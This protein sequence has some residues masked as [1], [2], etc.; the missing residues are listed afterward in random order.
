MKL[1]VD[2]ERAEEREIVGSQAA[3]ALMQSHVGHLLARS[4]QAGIQLGF[5]N[6]LA[7]APA[8]A[9]EV[10]ASCKTNLRAT[11]ALLDVLATTDYATCIRDRY[12]LT[13]LGRTWL[14]AGKADYVRI[15]LLEWEWHAQLE[16]FLRS[17]R[18][19]DIHRNMTAENWRI[20][21]EAMS[22]AAHLW[23]PFFVDF[24]PIPEGPCTLLDIGGGHGHL[25]V[26][27][28]RKYP[29]LRAVV[30]DLPGAVQASAPL[31]A[32]DGMGDRV[33]HL[34]GD[35]R[36]T[37]F[38]EGIYD[39]VAE[40]GLNHVLSGDENADLV[41]RA[42]RALRPGGHHVLIDTYME[43]HTSLGGQAY[44]FIA[45]LMAL[46]CNST[47]WSPKQMA[48]WQRAA[49]LEPLPALDAL[50]GMALQIAR[51]PL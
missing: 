36:T 26:L 8:T 33:V 9:D 39:V 3:L 10:A 24:V 2:A 21:E 35:A 22:A 16:G 19:I 49:K 38:G 14:V 31:L 32:A 47:L 30:V 45:M 1:L 51:K 28:C 12:A 40:A 15:G 41:K 11:T 50:P 13:D 25:S 18:G 5:F 29:Q 37:D 42:A 4:L 7:G 20:Y 43:P 17:D 44:A 34:V 6:A 46:I 27:L 48:E 23:M